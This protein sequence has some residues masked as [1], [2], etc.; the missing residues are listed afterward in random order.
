MT[1]AAKQQITA[2]AG[3]ALAEGEG[4]GP[5]PDHP[6]LLDHPEQA[7]LAEG[8]ADVYPRY[9][10]TCEWDTAAADAILRAA[11]GITLGTNGA[12]LGYG[13]PTYL[14]SSFLGLGEPAAAARLPAFSG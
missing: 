6:A 12:P 3:A 4:Q 11:G 1:P 2:A 9:G 13:K 10:P 7:A 14:N 8:L 5:V